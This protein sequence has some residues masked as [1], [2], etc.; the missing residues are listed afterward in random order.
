MEAKKQG[1]TDHLS[2]IQMIM[3]KPKTK[4]SIAFQSFPGKV[5]LTYTFQAEDI[6]DIN[7]DLIL[8]YN[9]HLSFTAEV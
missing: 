2:P 1:N 7:E 6:E 4:G 8:L 3:R 5:I 9:I